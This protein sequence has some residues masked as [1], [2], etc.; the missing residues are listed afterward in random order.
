MLSK[1]VFDGIILENFGDTPFFKNAVPPETI[2]SM[3]VIAA[4]VRETST[5]PLGINVLRNDARAAIAIGAVTGCQFI[6]VNVLSGVYATDQGLI[7]GEAAE[8]VRERAKLCTNIAI[9]ADVHVKHARSLSD[10]G[11]DIALCIE[12]T[13]DRA[14]ADAV[15]ISG[16]A[17]SKPVSA[18]DLESASRISRAKHIPLYVGSGVQADTLADVLKLADGIIVSSA[19]RKAGRAG[20]PLDS[21]RIKNFVKAFRSFRK[22]R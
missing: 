13:F 11:K 2:A 18:E 21:I 1:A 5:L 9:L 12:E 22:K 14:G 19:L 10:S 4:A 16:F 8:L 7:E 17:T 20:A 15:I 3:S 6:R